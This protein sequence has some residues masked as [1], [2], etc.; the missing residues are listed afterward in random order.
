LA[1]IKSH[2]CFS[3]TWV[4]SC[5]LRYKRS[6]CN[7]MT[8][9]RSPIS[10]SLNV[11]LKKITFSLPRVRGFQEIFSESIE[12]IIT[13]HSLF[14]ESSALHHATISGPLSFICS[15]WVRLSQSDKGFTLF[16]ICYLLVILRGR[17]NPGR[18]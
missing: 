17:L 11:S 6:I 18:Y 3:W 9:P 7:L 4:S 10:I 13:S 5:A 16:R 12:V 1:I 14:R 2:V 8:T 15:T